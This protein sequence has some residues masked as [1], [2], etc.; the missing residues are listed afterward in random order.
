MS[1]PPPPLAACDPEGLTVLEAVQS[2][3]RALPVFAKTIGRA[4]EGGY[5][6]ADYD[7]AYLC[8]FH[9]RRW[10]GLSAMEVTLK[11]L[12]GRPHHCIVRGA[13]VAGLDL[14]RPQR[15]LLHPTED[16][17]APTLQDVPRCWCA[18]DFD[19]SAPVADF[20][21]RADPRRALELLL[22]RDL[23]APFQGV[24]CVASFTS[25][26][27]FKRSSRWRAFFLLDRAFGNR[28]LRAIVERINKGSRVI[29]DPALCSAAQPHYTASPVFRD[30]VLDP[31]QNGRVFTF[32][33]ERRRAS[34]RPVPVSDPSSPPP[35]PF[36]G[37]FPTAVIR[38]LDGMKT[39]NT[40]H[41]QWIRAFAIWFA[42]FGP[43]VDPVPLMLAVNDVLRNH[44]V[45][46]R[47]EG[48]REQAW[49]QMSE[50]A[51]ALRRRERRARDAD[52]ALSSGAND[53]LTPEQF[54]VLVKFSQ[55]EAARQ[56]A[57]NDRCPGR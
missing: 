47:G 52:A 6:I 51:V 3:Y 20:D 18:L 41:Q 30:G 44:A 50:F 31:L 37:K 22:A 35:R 40:F 1:A 15:R 46:L 54:A 28:E 56:Q 25:G 27:G 39:G 9:L 34:L 16:G 13:P 19:Q 23:P 45:P 4:P 14:A 32:V 38:I 7:K 49:R 26:H 10:D 17:A 5:A 42:A 53:G 8:R 2:G 12:A 55:E 21:W 43:D 29:L 48:Y 33:M 36:T 24:D 11:G 57:A